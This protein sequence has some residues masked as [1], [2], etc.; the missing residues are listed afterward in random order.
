LSLDGPLNGIQDGQ[1]IVL[2]GETSRGKT[3]WALQLAAAA[4]QQSLSPLIWGLEMSAR[5]MFRR[6][7]VQVSSTPLSKSAQMTFQDREAHRDAV[8]FLNDSPVWF[9]T[10]S[11]SVAAFVASL[12]RLRRQAR[13]G[14]AVVDY[15]QLIRSGSH[16]NRADEVSDNSRAL[17]LAAMDLEIPI[18]VL[19]QV[20]RSSVKGD[21]EIGLHS[22]KNSGDIEN[23]ADVLLWIR[24]P[25]FSRDSPTECKIHIGK[26]REGPVGF[27]IKLTFHPVT[28]R[29]EEK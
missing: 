14:L 24:A 13:L 9:D 26:Q 5:S 12:R 20:D 2:L 27:E 28:Q 3:S 25:E 18:L 29:F 19:S 15:L 23:D 17:K 21:G 7:V 11:R 16:R 8:A 6:L 1:L 4:A 22:A 10:R